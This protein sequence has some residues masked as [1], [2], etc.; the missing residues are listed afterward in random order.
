MWSES[1]TD[2]EAEYTETAIEGL[3]GVTWARPV[4][5]RLQQAGGFK[6]EN[7]PLMF[8][9]RVAY[10][11]HRAGA[12]AE[13]EYSAGVGSSTI[14]FCV[15]GEIIWLIE[16]VSVRA[17]QAAKKAIIQDG[18]IYKQMLST[19][20]NDRAQS[21]EAEMITAQ[22][23]IGE[24]V[25]ADNAPTKF[26]VPRD[27]FC[28]VILTDMR[29]YLDEGGDWLDYRQ[30]AYGAPGIPPNY[31]WATHYWNTGMGISEPIRGLFEE[32]CPLRASPF[33]QERIHFL[34]F[35]CERDYREGEI[36]DISYYLPN[37]NLLSDETAIKLYKEFPL[38]HR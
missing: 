35:V 30:I 24:K 10:E 5:D 14:E 9:V 31:S 27:N 11:L 36:Q 33:I 16:L 13:Y 19:D 12:V 7:M 3:K 15:Q 23:K 37:P 18:F 22:Q 6:S 8:E 34:G 32:S 26:P 25:F 2:R 20:A 21:P 38:K 28:H 4:L 1:L 29:G 17:S